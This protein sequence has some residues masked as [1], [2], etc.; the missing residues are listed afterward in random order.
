MKHN[1]FNWFFIFCIFI[2]NQYVNS[3]EFGFKD[4]DDDVVFHTNM[5]TTMLDMLSF[6]ENYNNNVSYQDSLASGYRPLYVGLTLISGA[7]NKGAGIF[8]HI[9]VFFSMLVKMGWLDLY[10]HL[11]FFG[12][13]LM[14]FYVSRFGLF[15]CYG[16]VCVLSFFRFYGFLAFYGV[17]RFIVCDLRLF[18]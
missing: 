17:V 8:L 14:F 1:I 9:D 11:C 7:A 4:D 3:H 18:G 13:N 2:G 5:S 16:I 6:V 12:S 10:L 15:C